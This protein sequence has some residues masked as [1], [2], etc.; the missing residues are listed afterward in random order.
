MPATLHLHTNILP[1]RRIEFSLPELPEA[2]TVELLITLPEAEGTNGHSVTH[3][4]YP[5]ALNAEYR[6]LIGKKL[7]STLTEEEA[8]RL[9]DI[10]NVINEID[11]LTNPTPIR[12]QQLDIIEAKL[13]DIR[14]KIE[15]L[16][17]P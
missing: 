13:M 10:R 12:D 7:D 11:R 8:I 17:R 6:F 16:P 9:E 15:A 4:R 3:S 1:G 14:A 2:G 5:D